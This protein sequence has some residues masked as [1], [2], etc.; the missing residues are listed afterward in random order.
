MLLN[1]ENCNKKVN[2]ITRNR[3][4]CLMKIFDEDMNMILEYLPGSL[5]TVKIH[6]SIQRIDFWLLTFYQMIAISQGEI[7][8]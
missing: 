2:R 1:Y 6:S 3:T 7:F 5:I 4:W 8:K